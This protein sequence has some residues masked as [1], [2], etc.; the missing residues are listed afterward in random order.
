MYDAAALAWHGLD[1]G[2]PELLKLVEERGK[3]E[4]EGRRNVP[5]WQAAIPFLGMAKATEAVPV[6]TGI[7]KDKSA[8]IDALIG[9]VRALGRIG[10][11]SA[12]PALREFL[13]REDMPTTRVMNDGWGTTDDWKWQI[14]LA[15]AEALSKLGA[16]DEETHKIIKPY[17]DDNR[18]YVRRYADRLLQS[19]A[20]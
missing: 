6:L 2:V 18:A 5:S 7:L 1:A 11:E 3:E 20:I 10:D 15:T 8:G 12:V 19:E 17:L 13:K 4:T 9:A 14:D 16:S